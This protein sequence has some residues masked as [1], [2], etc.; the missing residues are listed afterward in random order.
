MHY[1]E[2]NIAVNSERQEILIAELADLGYESFVEG[3][4]EMK[5]Y[6]L[7]EDFSETT[8]ENLKEQYAT[9]FPIPFTF[10]KIKPENWNQ[11][12][13]ENFEPITVQDKVLVRSTFHEINKDYDYEIIINPKM[14]FGTGHHA[15][16]HL[17]IEFQ[18]DLDFEA[19][20]VLDLG[21]GTGIL[22]IMASKLR[23][24]II[25][26]CDNDAQAVVNCQ[27][28]ILLNQVKNM[29]VFTGTVSD[30]NVE[31]K[32]DILLANINRN[33]LL[34]EMNAYAQRSKDNAYLVLSG[35]YEIDIEKIL[36]E[37]EPQGFQFISKKIRND[38][39]ALLLQ[40]KPK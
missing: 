36:K 33:V 37:A 4:T 3:E 26:A 18:L 28:N 16:T 23:A 30:V 9:L 27:E 8:L 5:A 20:T 29:N 38:W 2:V 21:T 19:K 24:T 22:G 10:K 14:A 32:Y 39:S 40:Y 1:Y 34:N 15:T 35:F 31:Q 13:E 12:W 17:M 7:E 25:E 6:I 11:K